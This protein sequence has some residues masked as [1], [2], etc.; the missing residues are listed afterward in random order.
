MIFLNS[1][2]SAAALMFYLPGMCTHTGT[3]GKQ[4]KV[5]VFE[6]NTIFNEHPVGWLMPFN[7]K[8]ENLTASIRMPLVKSVPI[9][10]WK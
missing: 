1:A 8:N 3:E 10:A 2:S 4:R 9:G 7:D 6:K 5:R